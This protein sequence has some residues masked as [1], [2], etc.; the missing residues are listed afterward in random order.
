MAYRD[1]YAV[2][3]RL[4]AFLRATDRVSG[5]SAGGA[6]RTANCGTRCD[7]IGGTASAGRRAD[8]GR[9]GR[10]SGTRHSWPRLRLQPPGPSSIRRACAIK[11]SCACVPARY[12]SSAR[13]QTARDSAA[14][15][16]VRPDAGC[17]KLAAR[18]ACAPGTQHPAGAAR[19]AG[20]ARDPLLRRVFRLPSGPPG[21][22]GP[23]H[24]VGAQGGTRT[25]TT[26]AAT[27]SR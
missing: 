27:T 11:P 3:H 26:E 13:P 23:T 16:N 2:R 5:C 25:P 6:R 22:G 10:Q 21:R 1:T 20:I 4:A 9:G 19:G 18:P 15:G 7:R 14:G 24:G 12:P 17:R 8:P